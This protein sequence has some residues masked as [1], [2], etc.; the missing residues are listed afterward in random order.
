[1]LSEVTQPFFLCGFVPGFALFVRSSIGGCPP[2]VGRGSFAFLSLYTIRMQ[3]GS[4]F[5]SDFGHIEIC[6]LLSNPSLPW[7]ELRRCRR[8]VRLFTWV[9][10]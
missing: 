2:C 1:M 3:Q 5:P 9:V 10:G 6:L 7:S 4:V 8:W